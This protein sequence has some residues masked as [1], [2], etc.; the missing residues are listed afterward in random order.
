MASERLFPCGC[1]KIKM[2]EG[3]PQLGM[4]VVL[5][6]VHLGSRKIDGMCTQSIGYAWMSWQIFDVVGAPK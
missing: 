1:L 6:F 4:R 2:L 3:R 5:D